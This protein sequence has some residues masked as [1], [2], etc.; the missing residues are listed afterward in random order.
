[1]NK[2]RELRKHVE[3]LSRELDEAV[4]F[5]TS[6]DRTDHNAGVWDAAVKE[7]RAALEN[8]NEN[9]LE[10]T[11]IERAACTLLSRTHP[12]H[13]GLSAWVQA[14]I[15]DPDEDR[16]LDRYI[17]ETSVKTDRG[18]EPLRDVCQ[19]EEHACWQAEWDHNQSA[20]GAIIDHKAYHAPDTPE[21]TRIK[22]K[23]EAV[24]RLA[25]A[26]QSYR[27]AGRPTGDQHH[28][29]RGMGGPVL[30]VSTSLAAAVA[31][32]HQRIVNVYASELFEA[33][34]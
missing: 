7:A 8:E 10:V 5:A 24:L 9:G 27:R 25:D 32:Y 11:E 12:H 23:D 30:R 33:G 34:L 14:L 3:R 21:W 6:T 31:E 13:L 22:L 26:L 17:W 28:T 16:S 2:K 19:R 15:S 29:V 20:F 18:Q 4:D 1:M